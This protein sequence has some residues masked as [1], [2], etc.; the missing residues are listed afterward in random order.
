VE[1]PRILIVS[2][3]PQFSSSLGNRWR[4]EPRPAFSFVTPDGLD[5]L[6]AEDFELAIVA[7]C[8]PS[9]APGLRALG[10]SAVPIVEIA[11]G[12]E[13]KT[14]GAIRIPQVE[15]WPQL[16]E[17]L[18]G[19]VLDRERSRREAERL[20]AAN[21]KLEDQATLGRY[22][23]DMRLNLNNALTSILGN[24]EL[25]LASTEPADPKL[26]EQLRTIRNMGMRI[27][28]ILQR[29]SSVEK[30]MRL[31]GHESPMKTMKPTAGA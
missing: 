13:R 25:M 23:L 20:A 28:E 19:L 8:E 30:E 26:H 17:T 14:P 6:A 22:M 21:R 4:G 31:I 16:T 11:A 27:H 9:L 29:F 2:D 5:H 7:L 12:E 18:A 1:R 10:Q 3:D 24:S 15:D